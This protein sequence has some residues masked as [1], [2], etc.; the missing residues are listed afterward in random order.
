M[1]K[2]WDAGQDLHAPVLYSDFSGLLGEDRHETW[3]LQPQSLRWC[4]CAAWDPSVCPDSVL[5]DGLQGA[6]SSLP[7][8]V[9]DT[10]PFL[11]V[12]RLG[13]RIICHPVL[14]QPKS[15]IAGCCRLWG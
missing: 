9:V 3:A 4:S 13:L 7:R 14:S 5:R 15:I 11:A 6:F 8:V 1:S 2:V 10:V 12:E